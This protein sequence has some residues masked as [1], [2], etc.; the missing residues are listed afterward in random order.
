MLHSSLLF[1]VFPFSTAFVRHVQKNLKPTT[2]ERKSIILLCLLLRLPPKRVIYFSEKILHVS[3]VETG[4]R[5]SFS[6][7][8]TVHLRDIWL[9][10]MKGTCKKTHTAFQVVLGQLTARGK[11][12]YRL[13]MSY[14]IPWYQ[15]IETNIFIPETSST[16]LCVFGITLHVILELT[17]LR[18]CVSNASGYFVSANPRVLPSGNQVSHLSN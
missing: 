12:R 17:S 4:T 14:L 6:S 16:Q 10:I 8:W 18:T 5:A 2:G 7:K 13:T 9:E 11:I 15:R 1:R 3:A